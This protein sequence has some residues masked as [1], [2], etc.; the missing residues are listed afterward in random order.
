MG[1][2]SVDIYAKE[3][4][5]KNLTLSDENVVKYLILYRSQLDSY[6]GISTNFDI[7]LAGDVFDM[8]QELIALY[9]SLDNL[10]ERTNLTKDESHF[11]KL[12][13][14]GYEISEIIKDG[15][16]K[17]SKCYRMRDNVVRKICEKNYDVWCEFI[18]DYTNN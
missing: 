11:L 6:N 10:I 17:K 8:N 2:V 1:K 7:N 9:V 15:I 3:T 14:E 5:F 16:F 4:E 18:K 12:I 13:Y